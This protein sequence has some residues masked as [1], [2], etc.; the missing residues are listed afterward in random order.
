MMSRKKS[1]IIGKIF[2]KMYRVSYGAK[3]ILFSIHGVIN[4]EHQWG[5]NNKH[6][7]V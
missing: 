6:V 7:Y 1:Q 2:L 4:E 3:Y 5:L